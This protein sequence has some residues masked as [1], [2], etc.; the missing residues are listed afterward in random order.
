MLDYTDETFVLDNEALYNIAQR[1]LKLG[2]PTMADLNHVVSFALSGLTTCLRFPGQLNADLRKLAVNMVP[3]PRLHFFVP[4]YAPLF[5]AHEKRY[6]TLTVP[7]LI[8]QM[9]DPQNMMAA[10]NTRQGK[11]LTAASV[12]RGHVSTREVEAYLTE[13]RERNSSSFCHWI[14]GNLSRAIC[15][16]AA[17]GEKL[18][19]TFMG[20]TTALQDVMKRIMEQYRAM[21]KRKAFMH[22][23]L[24][25]GMDQNEFAEAEASANDMIAEY[26]LYESC[27]ID[28]RK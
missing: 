9:L 10:C 28:E 27:T 17:P 5:G 2:Q 18:T 3:F 24:G 13:A 15:D 11:Y 12:F 25:E 22:W 20:N 6:K 1:T 26:Q 21:Y 14:P 23:Y 16:I 8:T 4:G 19:S 7:E